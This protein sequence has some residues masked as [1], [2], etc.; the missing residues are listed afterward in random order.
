VVVPQPCLPVSTRLQGRDSTKIC[1]HCGIEEDV[2]HMA[3]DC[4][5][6][7]YIHEAVFKEWWARTMDSTWSTTHS[8]K[9]GCTEIP[10]PNSNN[11]IIVSEGTPILCRT[12]S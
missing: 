8:F 5:V 12:A 3:Y 6:A 10:I 11:D 4:M 7:E 1:P 9:R 2:R